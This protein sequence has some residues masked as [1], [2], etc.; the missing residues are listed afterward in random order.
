[1]DHVPGN[2]LEQAKRTF[3]L[4]VTPLF[5]LF[6]FALLVPFA[7]QSGAILGAVT[8]FA[9]SFVV[10]YWDLLTG[11]PLISFQWIFPVSLMAGVVAGGGWSLLVR[12]G[13]IKP[14][15]R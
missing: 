13:P 11:L 10:A 3:G 15:G 5:L 9:T 4:L 8:A 6:F 14:A 12:K 1:M 7:T 2:F